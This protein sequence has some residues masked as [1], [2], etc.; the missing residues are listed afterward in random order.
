MTE[1]SSDSTITLVVTM[2]VK[3]E[4]ESAFLKM[5]G[6]FIAWVQANEPGTLLYT[7]NK[8]TEVEHTYTW[9][10]RYRDQA[11]AQLH[12]SSEQIAKARAQLPDMLAKPGTRVVLHQVWPA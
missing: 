9:V 10:E 8:N 6:E 5:T 1:A 7:L 2:T 4:Q 3:P 11:A 12:G